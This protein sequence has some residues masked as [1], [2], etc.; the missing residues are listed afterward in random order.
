M[1]HS[2]IL[3]NVGEMPL[4]DFGYRPVFLTHVNPHFDHS[5]CW[6]PIDRRTFRQHNFLV[7]TQEISS[8]RKGD[9]ICPVIT[10][11]LRQICHDIP[12]SLSTLLC[13]K[14]FSFKFT[15]CDF[16]FQSSL[17]TLCIGQNCAGFF[18]LNRR[19]FF[20]IRS[21]LYKFVGLH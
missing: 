16:R 2:K 19:N 13:K 4:S 9:M 17:E 12:N 7:Y 21:A 1:K 18:L 5:A 15:T 20:R 8:F 6:L 11:H 14:G 3:C 10:R